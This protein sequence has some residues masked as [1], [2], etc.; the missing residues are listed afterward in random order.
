MKKTLAFALCVA[1]AAAS[2]FGQISMTAQTS[3]SKTEYHKFEGG[4][5][6]IVFDDGRKNVW[7]NRS[8]FTTRGFPLCIS[9]IPNVALHGETTSVSMSVDNLKF[10]VSNWGWEIGNHGYT[11]SGRYFDNK[12]GFVGTGG[13]VDSMAY[14]YERGHKA[15]VDT[16]G[17]DPT[18]WSSPFNS[19]F[20]AI[21]SR[22]SKYYNVGICPVN[23]ASGYA[24]QGRR[25]NDDYIIKTYAVGMSGVTDRAVTMAPGRTPPPTQIAQILNESTTWPASKTRETIK[26]AIAVHGVV[27]FIGHDPASWDAGLGGTGTGGLDSV[28]ALM[29][30]VKT[31]VD[32]GKLKVATLKD[33]YKE[34]YQ[35]KIDPNFNFVRPNFEDLDGNGVPDQMYSASYISVKSD[36]TVANGA[37]NPGY[38]TEG[39]ITLDWTGLGAA[40]GGIMGHSVSYPWVTRACEWQIFPPAGS[41]W[42]VRVEFFAQVDTTVYPT[43]PDAD[44]VGVMFWAGWDRQWNRWGSTPV[45]VYDPGSHGSLMA[46]TASARLTVSTAPGNIWILNQRDQIGDAWLHCEATWPLPER[47]EIL[48]VSIWKGGRVPSGAIRISKVFIGFFKRVP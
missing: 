23:S 15:L 8:I 33:V 26:R 44:S 25:G 28:T 43:Y 18:Y 48:H 35:K 13:S 36:S 17:L 9:V 3:S 41:G 6:V 46:Y 27:M 24:S 30:W 11:S 2:S 1:L 42:E 14:D 47:A 10:A 21:E 40:A 38:D 12:N 4:Y 20:W 34:F 7:Q 31:Y 16:M 39:Y 5:L 45:E 29:D 32:K 19:N 37:K 22:V